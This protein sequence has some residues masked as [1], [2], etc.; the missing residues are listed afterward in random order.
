MTSLS[1]THQ[2]TRLGGGRPHHHVR[3]IVAFVKT[4][5]GVELRIVDET[6]HFHRSAPLLNVQTNI[7]KARF[8]FSGEE[9]VASNV[10]QFN[11]GTFVGSDSISTTYDWGFGDQFRI[12]PSGDLQ[13][14]RFAGGVPVNYFTLR[15]LPSAEAV[16][17]IQRYENARAFQFQQAQQRRADREAMFD[18][19]VQ[20]A[21]M[22]GQAYSQGMREAHAMNA[23]AQALIDQAAESDRKYNEA[24][25][26]A[27]AANQP[28]PEP[29]TERTMTFTG[30]ADAQRQTSGQ[31]GSVS[32][33]P[34]PQTL[35]ST[36][37]RPS[38]QT[39][40][41]K[42]VNFYLIV[43][44]IPG[45]SNTRN[46]RCI[47]EIVSLSDRVDPNDSGKITNLVDRYRSGFIDECQRRGQITSVND[48]TYVSD[49]GQPYGWPN[50]PHLSRH[51]ED[52]YVRVN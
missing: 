9:W 50:R 35:S 30:M 34:K 24:R 42:P 5:D 14:T 2:R 7:G 39:A 6:G 12:L 3:T 8:V 1:T 37:T 33:A 22:V 36:P 28:P 17:A 41:G 52:V 4:G 45:P 43:G 20:G 10:V 18:Q 51:P 29:R 23:E 26:L 31:T 32:S 19:L 21:L 25:R 44:L 38:V 46:I 27:A 40:E 49:I 16:Q 47:S 15:R 13:T 11:V 48:V